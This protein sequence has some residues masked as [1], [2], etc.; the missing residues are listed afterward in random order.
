MT[1]NDLRP[2]FEALRI[3]RQIAFAASCCERMLPNYV[4]FSRIEKWGDPDLLRRSLDE[5]WY[6]LRGRPLSTNRMER[7]AAQCYCVIPHTE[8]FG[9][10]LASAALDAAISVTL[11][12]E[13]CAN[14]GFENPVEVARNA[15]DTV[16]MFVH[17]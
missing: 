10:A 14:P 3:Q 5:V 8:D 12:L 16:D 2:R 6:F 11:T 9:S 13:A 4:A 7:L 15:R 17:H 1:L